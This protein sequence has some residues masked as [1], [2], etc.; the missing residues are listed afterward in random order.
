MAAEPGH[1]GHHGYDQRRGGRAAAGDGACYGPRRKPRATA[2]TSVSVVA[3]VSGPAG[4]VRGRFHRHGA[5][6]GMR[7]RCPGLRPGYRQGT[8]V[9]C[10]GE[11]PPGA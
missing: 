10:A 11:G 7:S 1:A 3:A 8:A 9:G 6:P 4:L 2:A 5:V